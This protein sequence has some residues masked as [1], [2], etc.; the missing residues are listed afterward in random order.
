MLTAWFS[1]GWLYVLGQVECL[2]LVLIVTTSLVF[3]SDNVSA[4]LPLL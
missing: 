2:L 1:S 4:D 3:L